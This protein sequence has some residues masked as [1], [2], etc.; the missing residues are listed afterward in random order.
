M[1]VHGAPAT[2]VTLRA[3]IASFWHPDE[4]VLYVGTTTSSLRKRVGA[5]YRTPL[6]ARRPHAGGYFLKTLSNL[7]DLWVYYAPSLNPADVEDE[8]V[9]N[10]AQSRSGSIQDLPFANLKFPRGASKSHGVRYSR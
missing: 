8:M 7:S 10:F 6:G 4:V 2:V 5:Y 3:A 1:K 9:L